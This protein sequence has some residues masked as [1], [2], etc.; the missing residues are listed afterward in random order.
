[1]DTISIP[2]ETHDAPPQATDEGHEPHHHAKKRVLIALTAIICVLGAGVVWMKWGERI[3][4]A[5]T[6]GEKGA[7]KVELAPATEN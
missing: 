4:E 6:G 2:P 5:C 3:K 1:M 7:C